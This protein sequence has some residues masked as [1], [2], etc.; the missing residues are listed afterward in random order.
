[1]PLQGTTGIL[2]V[3][4]INNRDVAANGV[5]LAR[6]AHSQSTDLVSRVMKILSSC[7]HGKEHLEM[8]TEDACFIA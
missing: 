8:M 5:S 1:M 4:L 7:R 2:I 3:V 6:G